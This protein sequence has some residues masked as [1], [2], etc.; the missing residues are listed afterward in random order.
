MKYKTFLKKY[1]ADYDERYV[2]VSVRSISPLD[3]LLK[4]RLSAITGVQTGR[5]YAFRHRFTSTH[6][7]ENHST[8]KI[9]FV[10]K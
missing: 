6:E 5:L 10:C 3:E 9:R 7:R 8:H 2:C 1:N 4:Y